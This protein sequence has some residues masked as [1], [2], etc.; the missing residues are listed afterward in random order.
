LTN[1][2]ED[3]KKDGRRKEKV[4]DAHQKLKE[5]RAL[6][7]EFDREFKKRRTQQKATYEAR[8]KEKFMGICT[9]LY[10]EF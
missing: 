1:G 7:P 10:N 5:K 8:K 6:D 9:F 3:G 4:S 2:S